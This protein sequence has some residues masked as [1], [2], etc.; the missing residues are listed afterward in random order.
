MC[1]LRVC[2]LRVQTSAARNVAESGGGSKPE[3]LCAFCVCV[4]VCVLPTEWLFV[5]LC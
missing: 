5:L 4:C 2:V 3:R 1:I